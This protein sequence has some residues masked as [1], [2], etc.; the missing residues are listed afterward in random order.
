MPR[1]AIAGSICLRRPRH[2]QGFGA[3]DDDDNDDDF[4]FIL[5]RIKYNGVSVNM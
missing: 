5:Y 2:I 1:I 3:N 4:N